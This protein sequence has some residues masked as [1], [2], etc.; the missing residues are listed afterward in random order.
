MKVSDYKNRAINAVWKE[1]GWR[2]N[3]G[4]VKSFS[5]GDDHKVFEVVHGEFKVV[6][7]MAR[8]KKVRSLIYYIG[9]ERNKLF[10]HAWAC[11]QWRKLDIPYQ[12]QSHT[13]KIT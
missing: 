7:R 13:T 9:V 10:A 2:V 11:K 12:K 8:L 5:R 3:L 1:L 4:D 6:V